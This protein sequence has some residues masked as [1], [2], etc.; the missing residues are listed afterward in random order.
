VFTKA[1]HWITSQ[2]TLNQSRTLNSI[3][4]KTHFNIILQSKSRLLNICLF[5]V[6]W[7]QF[8]M[9]FLPFSVRA[10]CPTDLILLYFI[11]LII[12][13]EE[14]RLW[15]LPLREMLCSR[16]TLCLCLLT[17]IYV[18]RHLHNT[19]LHYLYTILCFLHYGLTFP[20]SLGHVT[21]NFNET[22]TIT[23]VCKF[24]LILQPV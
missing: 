4:F 2:A 20:S 5:H 7:L 10:K 13:G 21:L 12:T 3:Y 11:D 17:N 22:A 19:Q 24:I 6:S 9:N 1:W 14:W 18:V 23:D 8:C 16:I 15:S